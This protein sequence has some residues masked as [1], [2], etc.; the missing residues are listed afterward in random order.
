MCGNC[1]GT[2]QEGFGLSD[3][4]QCEACKGRGSHWIDPNARRYTLKEFLAKV[5]LPSPAH[6]QAPS[7]IIKE[8]CPWCPFMASSSDS[9]MIHKNNYHPYVAMASITKANGRKE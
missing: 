8:K 1:H 9:M 5:D 2:G 7:V 6:K 4:G 3:W